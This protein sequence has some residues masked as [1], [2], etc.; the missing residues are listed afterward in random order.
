[1]IL[2][3]G[4]L[5]S[6]K[7]LLLSGIGPEAHLASLAIP[8]QSRQISPKILLLSGIGPEAYLA[9]LAIPVQAN[10][11]GVGTGLQDHLLLV[12]ANLCRKKLD[13][14]DTNGLGFHGVLA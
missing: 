4:A 6:P 8:V 13:A 14:S 12:T 10:N 11:P 5:I 9:S 2:C 1:V 3:A 7:I